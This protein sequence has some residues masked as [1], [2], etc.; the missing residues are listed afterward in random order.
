MS[1]DAAPIVLTLVGMGASVPLGILL[2]LG[3]R[4]KMP[5]VASVSTGYIGARAR[6]AA[7]YGFLPL[8]LPAGVRIDP[9]WRISI[10]ITQPTWRRSFAAA[11][12][13]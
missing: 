12:G 9:F 1:G 5:A 3:R 10:A 2:A 6:G 7:R 11:F 8:L 4:S 13:A